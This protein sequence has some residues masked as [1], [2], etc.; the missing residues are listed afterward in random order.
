MAANFLLGVGG[1][2][3]KCVEAFARLATCGLGPPSAWVGL[4]DQDRSNGNAARTVRVLS[5]YV[6]L[7]ATLRSAGAN[8]LGPGCAMLQTAVERP[9]EGWA[10]AP[11]EKSSATL[12]ASIG[13]SGLPAE[14]TALVEMLF[15]HEERQLKL[16]EGFRQRP[17]L[18]AALT[19]TGVT[20]TSAVWRDLLQAVQA[21]G[22]GEEVRVFLVASIF[23]GTGASGLP[24]V[25]RLLRREIRA[26]GLEGKVK[27]GAAL[28]LPYFAFPA[29]PGGEGPAIRP[30]STTFLMQARGA[31]EYYEQLFR[32]EPVFDA[33][34]V[35]GSDPLIP[36]ESYSDGGSLQANPPLLPEFVAALAALDFLALRSP[37]EGGT[38]AVGVGDGDVV[39]WDDMPWS[40]GGGGAVRAEVGATL[41]SAV[42]WREHYAPAL[43]GDKWRA[44]RREA[45][46]RNHV[47]AR[48]EG[49]IGGDAA[50]R[51][52]TLVSRALDDLLRW[53]VALNRAGAGGGRRLALV[54]DSVL[55]R[56]AR[57]ADLTDIALV[58]ELGNREFQRM[59]PPNDGPD[60][61]ELFRRLTY[62]RPVDGAAGLGSVLAAIRRGCSEGGVG[63]R[64]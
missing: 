20:P 62:S 2:G 46:F 25:A 48:G 9:A 8:D 24:T 50:Q 3:A 49:A 59:I 44:H 33:L 7:R 23:G 38:F 54:A 14:E 34:Y 4:L 29:P 19:L 43:A 42:A 15:S 51:A 11:E 41:R 32:A 63:A 18:G 45:W 57:T 13:Y 30:D 55:A 61:A 40:A 60:M 12:A 26:R 1:T 27:L 22:H 21:A 16:D 47:A 5:D 10:W 37:A 64:S 53:F 58:G 52:V 17:A 6:E 56:E 35:L 28:M 39:G 36:L 31:L